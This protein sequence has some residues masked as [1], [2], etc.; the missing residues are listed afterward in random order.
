MRRYD[1]ARTRADLRT[2][3]T[4]LGGGLV[5]G[6]VYGV[7]KHPVP[8]AG[9]ATGGLAG[10]LIC[11]A[12]VALE[13]LFFTRRRARPLLRRPMW[14]FVAVRLFVY[15]LVTLAGIHFSH[16]LGDLFLPPEHPHGIRLSAVDVAAAFSL[17]LAFVWLNDLARFMGGRVLLDLLL[18]RQLRPR[19]ETR[20][21]LLVDVVGSSQVAQALGDL[22]FH[23]WLNDVFFDLAEPVA[24]HGGRIYRYVGDQAI[25]TWPFTRGEAGE[26]ALRCAFAIADE[27]TARAT[28]YRQTYGIAPELRYVLHGGTVVAGEMGHLRREVVYLGEALNEA[29]RLERQAK[30]QGRRMIMSDTLRANIDLPPGVEVAETLR[31]ADGANGCVYTHVLRRTGDGGGRM[32]ESPKK[33]PEFVRD[34]ST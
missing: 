29:S 23:A 32:A 20:V 28:A 11:G 2:L 6:V 7:L 16:K 25:I 34:G 21:F 31:M 4:P 33:T 1:M 13:R 17:A 3:A 14:Q 24:R 12:L 10:A 22:R 15:L 9:A 8:L 19:H 30:A 27:I 26:R 5:L 18:G